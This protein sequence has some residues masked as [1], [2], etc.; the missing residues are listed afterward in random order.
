MTS[1]QPHARRATSRSTAAFTLIELLVVIA[2]I[3]ILI[4]LLLPAVQKVREAAARMKCSNNLKQFGLAIHTYNDT[5]NR[6][7]PSGNNWA[8][9]TGSWLVQTLPYMEQGNLYKVFKPTTSTDIQTAND[10]GVN[11][12]N[13]NGDTPGFKLPYGQCPSDPGA[14]H[15]NCVNYVGSLGPQ[16]AI[17]PC[18]FDPNQQYCNG[19]AFGWGYQ[20]SPD[21]GNSTSASDIRGLFNRLGAKITLLSITDGTSNTIAVGESIPAQHDHLQGGDWWNYNSGAAHCTTIIPINYQITSTNWC[22]PADR[23][24]N[25]WDV[26]WGFKSNHTNGANFLFADGS[27][28]FL[29]QSIDHGTYQR[30]GCRNDGVPVSI[31]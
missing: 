18:G 29:Q 11:A 26:S 28:H 15:Q 25:N 5:Y 10:V 14:P 23:C 16:C 1:L 9:D 31:P 20:T 13:P 3:A 30:L 17:G 4:G 24:W 21:H 6:L 2:I 7:P 22:S 19:Q 12:G 27:V 8:N